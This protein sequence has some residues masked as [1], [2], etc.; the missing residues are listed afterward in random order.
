VGLQRSTNRDAAE[1]TNVWTDV[2]AGASIVGT[3]KVVLVSGTND[4]AKF[5]LISK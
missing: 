3:N 2:S 1:P 4:L 5:R